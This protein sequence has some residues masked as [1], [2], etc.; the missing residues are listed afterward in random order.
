MRIGRDGHYGAAAKQARSRA[1]L[2]G[3][4]H[5]HQ[6]L[7]KLAV[8]LLAIELVGRRQLLVHERPIGVYQLHQAGIGAE[9]RLGDVDGL[10]SHGGDVVI[11]DPRMPLAIHILRLT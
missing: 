4:L 3:E 7:R 9:H 6:V 8:D 1:V 5:P 11:L 10:I 2:F